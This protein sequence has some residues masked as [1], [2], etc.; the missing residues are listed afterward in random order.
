MGDELFG[1]PERNFAPRTIWTGDNLDILRGLNSETIDLIYLDP[2]FNS[3]RSYSAPIGS[4]AAGAA[5]EDTW[6]LDRE[7]VAWMGL[8]ADQHP[9]IH[10]VVLA[11][12]TH[13]TGMQSYLRMMAVRLLEMHRLLAPTG[14]IYLHCDP[15]AS[16]YLKLLMDAVFG[17]DRFRNEIVWKR[18][19][20]HNRAK[21]WGPIHDT[22]L[23]YARSDYTWNRVLQPLDQDYISRFYNCD[24]TRGKFGM[25]DLTGP[26]MRDGDTG[27]PWRGIDPSERSRHWELPPDRAL[28][29]WFQFP[30]GY[31]TMTARDRLDV[32]DE[33][34]LIYWPPRGSVPRFKRYLTAAS[35]APVTDVVN[36]IPPI[37][38]RAKERL[39]FP[40]QKPVALLER[41]IEASSNRGDV[42]LDPFCGCATACVAA[43]NLSR[44][45]LGIDISPKA[46]ELV[47]MRLR[48]A[49]G[50]LYHHRLVTARTDIPQRTDIDNA[51]QLPGPPARAVRR[52]GG[53][54]QRLPVGVAVQDVRG[55]PHRADR[56]GRNRPSEQPPTPVFT[57]QPDQGR[58][59]DGISGR[60][61]QGTGCMN[62][63]PKRPL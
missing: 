25:F 39:G 36:D 3:N 29:A 31:S 63:Q 42:V 48:E 37:G 7:D 28:P 6:T 58:P 2:P 45:W 5:F 55:G 24:D 11:A 30:D 33:Q 49:L 15:T 60:P 34:D 21:R 16:H 57:V 17:R 12:G 51:D 38:A 20:S 47:H 40:T 9:D 44:E 61:A 19:S 26:G 4:R 46:V 56:A 27:Q 54:V 18:Q 32:L 35:G 10:N 41:I 59:T 22:V 62:M 1:K 43:D 8:I 53:S 13:S 14:S 23:F 52:A 50:S